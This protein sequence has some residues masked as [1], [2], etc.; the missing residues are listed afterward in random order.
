[1]EPRIQEAEQEMTKPEKPDAAI[2]T[3]IV[4]SLLVIGM[5]LGMILDR[6]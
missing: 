5:A 4:V 2:P 1:M 3:L 6:M